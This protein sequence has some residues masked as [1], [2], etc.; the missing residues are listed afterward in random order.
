MTEKNKKFTFE[1]K[2]L[3]NPEPSKDKNLRFTTQEE[4]SRLVSEYKK[5]IGY[6]PMSFAEALEAREPIRTMKEWTDYVGSLRFL[7][8]I[9]N[10][11]QA[12]ENAANPK[13]RYK[14]E[15]QLCRLADRL[16]QNMM[17]QRGNKYYVARCEQ[18][19]EYRIPKLEVIEFPS[20]APITRAEY[21]EKCENDPIWKIMIGDS[22]LETYKESLFSKREAGRSV[23]VKPKK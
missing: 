13:D 20:I 19:G 2:E 21:N 4:E 5:M 10:V 12:Y 8:N 9:R 23:G 14:A 11:V 18:D 16:G 3:I 17:V 1:R 22:E 15:S 7:P 6:K